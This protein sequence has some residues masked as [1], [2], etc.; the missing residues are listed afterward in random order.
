MGKQLQFAYI[1]RVSWKKTTNQLPRELG[2]I[3]P[4]QA[5]FGII[6]HGSNE[7]RFSLLFFERYNQKAKKD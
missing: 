5:F 2:Y 1:H 6:L 7:I 3:Q 4:Q